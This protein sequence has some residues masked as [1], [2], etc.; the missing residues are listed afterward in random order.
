MWGTDYIANPFFFLLRVSRTRIKNLRWQLVGEIT[1][2]TFR[3]FVA[4]FVQQLKKKIVH[5][6]CATGFWLPLSLFKLFLKVLDQQCHKFSKG[7][8]SN[9]S[10]ELSSQTFDCC[11]R[12][13]L[14]QEETIRNVVS[15]SHWITPVLIVM[16]WVLNLTKC[17]SFDA[18]GIRAEILANSIAGRFTKGRGGGY[19]Q[20]EGSPPTM[21]LIPCMRCYLHPPPPQ[22]NNRQ[23]LLRQL[24]IY[25]NMFALKYI[26]HVNYD[27]GDSS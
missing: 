17:F 1:P 5:K 13:F 12:N 18:Y 9:F 24:M 16:K 8:L 14:I 6:N 26:R 15:T 3:K 7:Y 27:F 4:L 11:P 21:W 2:V 23:L 22:Q 25:D 10:T 20:T 19:V